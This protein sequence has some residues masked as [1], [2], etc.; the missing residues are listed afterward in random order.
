MIAAPPVRNRRWPGAVCPPDAGSRVVIASGTVKENRVS[1]YDG[2]WETV[3]TRAKL[4]PTPEAREQLARDAREEAAR[5]NA[6]HQ[7]REEQYRQERRQRA[8]ELAQHLEATGDTEGAEQA[9]AQ[10]EKG[11]YYV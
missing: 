5:R 8:E 10:G 7:E 11:S 1:D 4:Q 9:R 2:D 3:L 6:A